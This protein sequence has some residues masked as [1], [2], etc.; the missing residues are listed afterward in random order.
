MA[1]TI[2]Q[3]NRTIEIS[4]IDSNY[5]MGREINVESV[6]FIPGAT[7][8]Q[9]EIREYIE[10][11]TTAPVKTFF[12][13][14]DGEPRVQYFNQRIRLCF[15]FGAASTTLSIGAKIIFNIGERV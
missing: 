6:V 10:E 1:N 9:I 5:I 8:D 15:E 14:G 11:I 13:S 4:E 12:I 3:S 2:K 7:D